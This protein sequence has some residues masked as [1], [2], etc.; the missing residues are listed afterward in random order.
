MEVVLKARE[1]VQAK[2]DDSKSKGKK[3]ATAEDDSAV[4]EFN[5][6]KKA[7]SSSVIRSLGFDPTIK[8][9][10]RKGE[11]TEDSRS[12]VRSTSDACFFPLG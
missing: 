7:Y 12:K 11:V 10:H 1:A 8:P 2:G 6:P 9:G 3:K 4:A 5:K